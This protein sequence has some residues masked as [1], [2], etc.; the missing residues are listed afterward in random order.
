[1]LRQLQLLPSSEAPALLLLPSLQQ[2]QP[3]LQQQQPHSL[4]LPHR[5]QCGQC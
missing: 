5:R 3:Q 4:L 1:L 2:L